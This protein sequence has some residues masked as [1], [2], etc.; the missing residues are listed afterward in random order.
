MKSDDKLPRDPCSRPVV[1]RATI[2]DCS[3]KFPSR[4]KRKKGY[5]G[6]T[7]NKYNKNFT[8]MPEDF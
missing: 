2:L 3:R 5:D 6:P 1:P 8:K 7:A 4:F